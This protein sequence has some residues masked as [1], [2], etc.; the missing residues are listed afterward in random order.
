[1]S[2][3]STGDGDRGKHTPT[4]DEKAKEGKQDKH[5]HGQWRSTHHLQDKSA[6]AGE[7]DKYGQQRG[8]THPLEASR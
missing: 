5:W 2:R 1:M 4:R 8:S 6:T 7:Q 3:K